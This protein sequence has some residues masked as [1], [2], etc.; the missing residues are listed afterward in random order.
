[1][2]S[3]DASRVSYFPSVPWLAAALV[4][5]ILACGRTTTPPA[6]SGG[7][8]GTVGGGRGWAGAVGLAGVRGQGGLVGQAGVGVGGQGA[9]GGRG[10]SGTGGPIGVGGGAPQGGRGGFPGT[11]GWGT[12]SCLPRMI[13][14]ATA[15]VRGV[16]PYCVDSGT[17]MPPA[18][19]SP[20]CAQLGGR[21]VPGAIGGP[22]CI[23]SCT[24]SGG[25]AGF[26]GI[27]GS[28]G[29]GG[30][31]WGPCPAATN[32]V[33]TTTV[34]VPGPPYC[35]AEGQG[36][37][38]MCFEPLCQRL[39]GAC[40]GASRGGPWCIRNCTPAG[41]Q[42]GTTGGAGSGGAGAGGQAGAAGQG[43]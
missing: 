20:R 23:R 13:C 19:G 17:V 24:R 25:L 3:G 5:P 30:W 43:P 39:G 32:T 27:G 34:F 28:G 33:C 40:V 18:C 11:G 9:L 35:V 21:C 1:M 16:G 10:G 41:G 2:I 6:A 14:T 8:G 15:Y 37:P 38:P 26:P 29:A 7:F 42:S 22:W 31:G 36:S 4:L 12:E